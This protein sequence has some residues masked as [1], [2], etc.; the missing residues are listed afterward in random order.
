M[1]DNSHVWYIEE[2]AIQLAIVYLT[3]RD[4]LLIYNMS[5]MPDNSFDLLVRIKGNSQPKNRVFGVEV[6]GKRLLQATKSSEEFAFDI[7]YTKKE[8]LVY[9][10]VCVFLFNMTNDEGFYR[11]LM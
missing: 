9:I 3:R 2:R 8:L 5:N 1:M 4:D 10:P 11:W 6:K 7:Q